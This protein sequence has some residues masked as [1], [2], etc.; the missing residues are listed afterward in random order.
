MKTDCP[1]ALFHVCEQIRCRLLLQNGHEV[2][3]H[4]IMSSINYLFYIFMLLFLYVCGEWR[5]AYR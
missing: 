3:M 4:E 5:G 2:P 1:V